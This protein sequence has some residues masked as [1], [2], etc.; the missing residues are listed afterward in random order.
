MSGELTGFHE[1]EES[2]ET[3]VVGPVAG[4]RSR[5]AKS[6]RYGEAPDSGSG[7]KFLQLARMGATWKIVALSWIG[8]A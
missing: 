1:W 6:G 3:H 2:A 7:T 5:Y 4:R 8:D